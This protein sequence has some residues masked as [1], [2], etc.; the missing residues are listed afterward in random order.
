MA[1]FFLI[2]IQKTVNY[3]VG[4]FRKQEVSQK[5][6]LTIGSNKLCKLSDCWAHS[7]W[8]WNLFD[9][10]KKENTPILSI[11]PSFALLSISFDLMV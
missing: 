10:L 1:Q 9:W 6:D 2:H 11:F 5:I 4:N 8:V 7:Y 3:K